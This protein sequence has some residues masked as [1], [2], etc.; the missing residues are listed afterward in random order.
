MVPL[1]LTIAAAVGGVQFARTKWT[2]RLGTS[3]TA[4]LLSA[5]LTAFVLAWIYA[6][7]LKYP[8]FILTNAS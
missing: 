5:F 3:I 7:V 6:I 2:G 8:Q 4:G 1:V